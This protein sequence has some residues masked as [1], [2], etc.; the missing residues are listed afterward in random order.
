MSRLSYF[1]VFISCISL[2]HGIFS[3][4]GSPD[5]ELIKLGKNF[6]SVGYFVNE[7]GRNS[8]SGF[9]VETGIPELEGRVVVTAA[10]LKIN[11]FNVTYLEF[12]TED[13]EAHKGTFFAHEKYKYRNKYNSRSLSNF[14]AEDI[15]IFL[16]DTGVNN[17]PLMP[18]DFSRSNS[19]IIEARYI[20]LC[21]YGLHKENGGF[22]EDCQRRACY[23]H[24]SHHL[25]LENHFNIPQNPS[26]HGPHH[27][28]SSS[29][30]PNDSQCIPLMGSESFI[31][32]SGQSI[33]GDSGGLVSL[34]GQNAAVGIIVGDAY[35][36]ATHSNSAIPKDDYVAI[37]YGTLSNRRDGASHSRGSIFINLH[38]YKDW[39]FQMC[40]NLKD[41]VARDN[42]VPTKTLTT[43]AFRTD[44]ISLRHLNLA[45][46]FYQ[47]T[48]F[49]KPLSVFHFS[50]KNALIALERHKNMLLA[51]TS[52][53]LHERFFGAQKLMKDPV[54]FVRIEGASVY[55]HMVL[56]PMVPTP[57]RFDAFYSLFYDR[58]P[59]IR[60]FSS[61]SS[62]KLFLK[63]P[64]NQEDFYFQTDVA[65]HL[66]N[67]S[68]DY[69]LVQSGI[70]Q[71][72]Q[73]CWYDFRS[74]K[75]VTCPQDQSDLKYI[76]A[77]QNGVGKLLMTP[78]PT[79]RNLAYQE[80]TDYIEN[81]V[82]SENIRKS[83]LDFAY[84]NFF[85]SVS[86]YSRYN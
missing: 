40:D 39:F 10:H 83:L 68:L 28:A 44:S 14:F 61:L 82:K 12:V 35:K 41:N 42:D 85:A 5:S 34:S 11:P 57:L 62:Q 50:L 29:L 19:D 26:R 86:L 32:P 22:F 84:Q 72:L 46:S 77:F 27:A 79:K 69:G 78:S 38:H 52:P 13:G 81:T 55:Y 15:G 71:F 54:H 45:E 17:I 73:L 56:D 36:L 30:E 24:V 16:L 70:K 23:A 66:Y 53:S 67:F 33:S 60:L 31:A 8:G 1:F 80:I 6:S 9:L 2:A 3:T 75:W 43:Q 59:S 58:D 37:N 65:F 21:G 25:N 76:N 51:R 18:L 64:P 20:V 7:D 49:A 47:S 48:V 4:D 63:H 74:S